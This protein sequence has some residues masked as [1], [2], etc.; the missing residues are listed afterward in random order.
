MLKDERVIKKRKE[1]RKRDRVTQQIECFVPVGRESLFDD[2]G[3]TE[4]RTVDCYDCEGV[5]ER[6]NV[7]FNETVNSEYLTMEM[8][9]EE[10]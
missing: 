9:Q 2:N 7:T 3:L 5:W 6:E 10:K 8:R 1:E 4:V